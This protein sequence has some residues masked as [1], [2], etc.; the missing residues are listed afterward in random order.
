MEVVFFILV[1]WI[2]AIFSFLFIAIITVACRK[3]DNPKVP[4]FT[5]VPIPL[6]TLIPGSDTKISGLKPEAFQARFTVDVYFKNGELPQQLDLVVVKN[7]DEANA[8]VL[9]II[10]SWP[11][12]FTITGQQLIDLFG[13]PIVSG[14]IFEISADITTQTGLKVSAFSPLGGVT[15]SPGVFNMPGSSPVLTFAAP[16]RYEAQAYKTDYIIERDDWGDYQPGE[17]IE[18]TVIDDTHLS[19][20]YKADGASPIIMEIDPMTNA[21]TVASQFYGNYNG[22]DYF[23][24]SIPGDDSFVDPCTT[25]ISINIRHST[26][27]GTFDGIIVMTKK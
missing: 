19:F 24:E 3:D 18:I 12:E 8:H 6:L 15:F 10:T 1:S 11:A 27:V 5:K 17:D 23:A 13:G 7:N 26:A 25:S 14:D 16:C 22:D 20:H 2:K 9:A 21:V 4:D